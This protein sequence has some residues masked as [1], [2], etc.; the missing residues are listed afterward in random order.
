MTGMTALIYVISISL[1][2]GTIS[3]LIVRRWGYSFSRYFITGFLASCGI[4]GVVF[5]IIRDYF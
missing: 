2:A 1:I 5:K 3:G 4:L